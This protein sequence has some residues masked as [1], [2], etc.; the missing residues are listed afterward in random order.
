MAEFRGFMGVAMVLARDRSERKKGEGMTHGTSTAL[1]AAPWHIEVFSQVRLQGRMAF[2]LD[3][4]V[5]PVTKVYTC[6]CDR[7]K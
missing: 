7:V 4:T 2:V 3:R 6:I 1:P 5:E